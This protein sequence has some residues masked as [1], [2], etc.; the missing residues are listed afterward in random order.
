MGIA[1]GCK[2]GFVSG[3]GDFDF[4]KTVTFFVEAFLSLKIVKSDK[5]T[6]VPNPTKTKRVKKMHLSG[7]TALL[8]SKSHSI[9]VV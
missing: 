3:D 7:F 6:V 4:I 1:L 8:Q 5:E 2:L 9:T